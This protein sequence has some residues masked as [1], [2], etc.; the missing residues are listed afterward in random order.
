MK[1][2]KTPFETL[3]ERA[4]KVLGPSGQKHLRSKERGSVWSAALARVGKAVGP[5]KVTDEQIRGTLETAL[6]VYPV[7]L[8][9]LS[10]ASP[11]PTRP[12]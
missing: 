1:H 12:S 11:P 6:A 3:C 9:I 4:L 8:E 2:A 7:E 5:D 10:R